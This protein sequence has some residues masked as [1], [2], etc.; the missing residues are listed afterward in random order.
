MKTRK[1]IIGALMLTLS[2]CGCADGKNA[3][4]S[5]AGNGDAA[6][7]LTEVKTT[8]YF[9][10][11]K[12]SEADIQKILSAGINAPSAMNTQPWHFAAV[13]D[14]EVTKKLADAMNSMKPPASADGKMPSPPNGKPGEKPK[15]APEKP[16]DA[17]EKPKDAPEK[18]ADAPEKPKDAPEKPPMPD[19]DKPGFSKAAGK[20]GIGDAPLTIVISCEDGAELSIGLAIQN[21]SA[22]A[23][24]LGYGTKILTSPTIALN[25]ENQAEY[26]ELL[27]I[28]ENQKVAAVL[29]V[30]KAASADENPDALSGATAR[31]SFEDVATVI[32]E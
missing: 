4:N 22:E 6:A 32:G 19:G 27:Q 2:L 13:T 1:T 16:A 25:G 17:P 3:G 12:V 24:L 31:N 8:Q 7:M 21:M 14:E 30:G 10:D 26:K 5:G 15:D 11:E 29:L 28:P 18:P 9:T 20:A 23:Q